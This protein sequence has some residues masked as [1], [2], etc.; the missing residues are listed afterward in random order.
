VNALCR[1]LVDE[2]FGAAGD[3]LVLGGVPASALAAAHGTPLYAYDAGI[4]RRR[5]E[6]LRAALPARVEI[7]YSVKANPNV[8]VIR[9]FVAAGAGCEI[10]SAGELLRARAAGCPAERILF[11]GPGKQ[12]AELERAVAAGIGEVHVESL[13]EIALLSSLAERAGKRVAVAIRV[14]P[15]AEARGGAMQMG[16]RPAA[17]G[18]DEEE[19]GAAAEAVRTARGLILTGV[20]MFAATQILDAAVLAEQ[21][22]HAVALAARLA[23]LA[24]IPIRTVDLGG[25]LGVPTFGE[26]RPLDLQALGAAAAELLGRLPPAL[27]GARFVLEPG[28]F[29]VAPA[30]VYLARVLRVKRSRGATF[31]VLDG[32]MNHH[33]AAS[34]NLGQVIRRDYPLLNASRLHGEPALHARLVG[35]LCTPLDTLAR[36]A[37]LPET[38][39][40]DLIALLQSGAY[41]LTASPVGFLS[42]PMPA[43]VLVEGGRAVCIRPRGT[44]EAPLS[45][46][47]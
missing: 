9:T 4:L 35:P 38:R 1:A 27:A 39:P 19:L 29:L 31:V 15:G 33:L 26:E 22:R 6:L 16:G 28:R 21:W 5:L 14:N 40:G 24:D 45:P 17:F 44:A 11:A 43:E 30:G 34:G 8:E 25:G 7:F 3:E 20:H 10:A 37:H 32:G 18:I 2:C 23:V 47:P 36:E 46:L 12:E 42:H 41:G 13:D